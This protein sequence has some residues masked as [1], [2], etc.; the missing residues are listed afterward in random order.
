VVQDGRIVLTDP[1]LGTN[2]VVCADV[3]PTVPTP[4]SKATQSFRSSLR[5]SAMWEMVNWCISNPLE[6]ENLA[7]DDPRMIA[8]QAYITHERRRVELS[9]GK[10]RK[11]VAA[12]RSA[13]IP[14]AIEAFI[15]HLGRSIPNH[16]VMPGRR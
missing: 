4:T 1:E 3:I 8:I 14:T 11:E 2:G 5:G 10:H 7:A 16:T 15:C 9:P 6:G 13:A 12:P